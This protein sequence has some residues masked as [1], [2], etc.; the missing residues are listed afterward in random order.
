MNDNTV[1]DGRKVSEALASLNT[2]KVPVTRLQAGLKSDGWLASL[3]LALPT[4]H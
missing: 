1:R 4:L 3:A 2:A